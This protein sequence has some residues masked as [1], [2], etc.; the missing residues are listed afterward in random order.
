MGFNQLRQKG[1]WYRLIP[2]RFPPVELY[3][4]IGDAGL[5][6]VAKSLEALTNP[7]LIAAERQ[8]APA[9]AET[10]S[11]LFQNWNHAPFAYKDPRGSFLLGPAFGVLELVDTKEGALAYA[12]LRREEFLAATSERPTTLDMR[13]LITPVDGRF[14]DLTSLDPE[15]G[16]AERWAIGQTLVENESQGAL[17]YRPQIS[18]AR[19]LSVFDRAVLGTTVQATHYRFVWDGARIKS[20]YDFEDKRDRAIPRDAILPAPALASP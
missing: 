6:N 8:G 11:P 16:Q 3:E 20:I 9:G 2:S 10:F 18:A 14:E 1:R 13:L 4:R 12:I 5:Q 7:R 19:F 15:L 17:T